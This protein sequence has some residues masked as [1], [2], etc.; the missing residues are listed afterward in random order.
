MEAWKATAVLPPRF[1]LKIEY[2][3]LLQPSAAGGKALG[4]TC[5][6]QIT[7][8]V[9]RSRH[10]L[11]VLFATIATLLLFTAFLVLSVDRISRLRVNGI[12]FQHRSL[13]Y[14]SD[15]SRF[16]FHHQFL[17]NQTFN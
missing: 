3:R 10:P 12:R 4:G 17:V 6:S 5:S 14:L 15:F 7:F 9:V 13:F 11:D 16:L 8:R 1:K 2:V